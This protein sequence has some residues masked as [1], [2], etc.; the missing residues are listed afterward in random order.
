VN[1]SAGQ[2]VIALAQAVALLMS[3]AFVTYTVVIFIHYLRYRP[4]TPG[5]GG[6]LAW[7]LFVPALNEEQVIGE[8]VD[9]LRATFPAANV[10]VIDDDSG[11][12]TAPIVARRAAADPLV[13]LVPRRE[14]D[15]RTGKGDALNAA[16]QALNQWLP[17][18]ADRTGIIV[19]VIDADGRPA[20]NCLDV[21]AG[22]TLFGDAAVGSVQIMV[23]MMNRHTARPFPR[24]GRFVNFL[25]QT[26]VRLQDL[27][28]R[29]PISAIQITRRS[30]R[31]V[32]LGGNGQFS[33][34]SALD[35]VTDENGRPW[36]GAL[37]EDYELS[38]HLMMAGH[39]NEYTDDTH[40]DQEGLPDIRRLVRQRTR[41][42]Q[43]TMQ[44]GIYLRQLWT[45]RHVSTIGA[46]EASYYLFQPWLQLVGTI[47]YPVP[48]AVFIANYAAGPAQMRAWV[49]AGGWMIVGYYLILGLGPFVAWG[50]VYGKRCERQVGIAGALG[51]GV[52]YSLFVTVIYIT[53]WRAL[54][55]ILRHRNEWFKTRRN[56]E[57]LADIESQAPPATVGGIEM[58]R[59][60]IGGN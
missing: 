48:L 57:F 38:L 8:T 5:D 4:R 6:T 30:T 3:V 54:G 55:R 28:F 31:T 36:R 41:W 34:L 12:R 24:R 19:G 9:Y 18:S 25:G 33:R 60:I 32:G 53:S 35:V 42:G 47:V 7:H 39:R 44:C 20:P 56:A 58:L 22:D 1:G 51:L 10:W 11:D 17:G 26:L 50:P 45:S 40:V 23:R 21:C 15:A 52:G 59:E 46:L 27:E 2:V 37:L 29:V 43:G 16:Y 13:H 49:A 14:P